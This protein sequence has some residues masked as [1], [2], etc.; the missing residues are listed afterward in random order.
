M[1]NLRTFFAILLISGFVYNVMEIKEN[2][3]S[4]RVD[5]I[6][7]IEYVMNQ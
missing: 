6:S 1:F 2:F 7:Q 3:V 4:H 5:R